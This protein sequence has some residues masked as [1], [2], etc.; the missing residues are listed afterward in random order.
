MRC[1][2]EATEKQGSGS[3]KGLEAGL[4]LLVAAMAMGQKGSLFPGGGGVG[5]RAWGSASGRSGYL[6]GS[7]GICMSKQELEWEQVAAFKL[8]V[9]SW[10]SV[11]PWAWL[12]LVAN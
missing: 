4:E 1:K 9:E 11:F 10:G 2:T 5:G 12:L 6:L 7:V 8:N 3:G